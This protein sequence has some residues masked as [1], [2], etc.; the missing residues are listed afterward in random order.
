MVDVWIGMVH[1]LCWTKLSP[2]VGEDIQTCVMLKLCSVSSAEDDGSSVV[3]M[4]DEWYVEWSG[5][6]G[7]VPFN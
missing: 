3:V 6:A 1:L 7:C 2:A 5:S 4:D